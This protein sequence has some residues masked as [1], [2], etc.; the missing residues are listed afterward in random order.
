MT[1][2]FLVIASALTGP[3]VG[4]GEWKRLPPLPDK[5]GFAGPFSGVSG[6][7]LLV[8]GGANFPGRKPWDGG[9]KVWYD[10]VF[11]LDRPGGKWEVAG[12]LPRPLG[13]GVSVTHRGGV[14]CVGGSD[15]DRHY[16]DV[17]RL[18][19]KAGRVVTT[20]LP[21]LPGPVANACGAVVGDT[22]YV[23]GGQATPDA[24]QTLKTVFAIDLAAAEP[25]WGEITA[26][27]GGGR[28][29]AVAAACDGA[30]WLVGGADLVVKGGAVERRYL[31]DAY[32]FDPGR[33]WTRVADLPRPVAAAPSPA[34]ADE[35]G[36][37]VLGGDDGAQV[38]E[39]PARHRGFGKTILRFD[40]MA[41]T[42]V[43]AGEIPAARVT[44]P[45]V[46]WGRMWVVPGGEVCP[47]VRSPDVWG[48]TPGKKE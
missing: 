19:W 15:A 28:M 42:W 32:R 12:K 20:R 9:K 18:D 11:V 43:E 40:P 13:Y 6:G 2:T 39:L 1:A 14:V 25:R 41:G 27:P 33:G 22:L 29:L 46:R 36:F 37:S 45:V 5:E 7:A 23:A 24:K 35:S 4:V 31:K 34:P 30:F 16:A 48:L 10:S 8:A 26:F 21:P 38:G 3:G 44:V 17:F 47:G